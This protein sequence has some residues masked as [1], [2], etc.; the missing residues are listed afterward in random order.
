MPGETVIPAD[1]SK[2]Y[3]SLINGMIAGNIP[4]YQIGR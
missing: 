3:G 2:K 1:M 4:G